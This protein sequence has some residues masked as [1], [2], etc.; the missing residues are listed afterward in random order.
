MARY[1]ILLFS[2]FLVCSCQSTPVPVKEYTLAKSAYDAAVASESIKYA[3]QL[4]HKAE[5]AY[6][7]GEI[8]YKER[9]YEAAREQFDICVRL[10]ERAENLARL[11]QFKEGENGE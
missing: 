8:L 10:S 5:K 2:S 1:V 3:P 6:K 4:F 11:K 9:D 7:K